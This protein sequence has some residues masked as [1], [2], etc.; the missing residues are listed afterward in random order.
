VASDRLA[1][2]EPRPVRER[3]DAVFVLA[4]ALH[5]FTGYEGLGVLVMFAKREG[6][7]GPSLMIE[8]PAPER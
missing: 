2:Q 6:V 8:A 7:R 1:R 5:Q 3:G 4:G